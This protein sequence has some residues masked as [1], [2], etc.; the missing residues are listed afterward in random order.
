ML[1]NLLPKN[2]FAPALLVGT[3]VGVGIFGIPYAFAKT[4]PIWGLFLLLG[5]GVVMMLLHYYYG[6]VCLRCDKK[7]RLVGHAERFLGSWA[8]RLVTISLSF[9]FLGA[10]LAYLIVA[11][12]F[13]HV[14]FG[15][16]QIGGWSLGAPFY[17]FLFWVAGSVLVYRGLKTIAVVEVVMSVFLIGVI[18]LIFVTSLGKIEIQNL[19]G[20]NLSFSF[21]AYGVFLTALGGQA[22]IPE[23]REMVKRGSFNKQSLKKVI[24]R[25]TL[26]VVLI[27]LLFGLAVAGVSG[28]A[29]TKEAIQGLIPF[30]G[31]NIALAGAVFGILACFTS[32]LV[33][34]D[35]LKTVFSHDWKLPHLFS[36]GIVT[37]LPLLAYFGG[38][39]DF[40]SIISLVGAVMGGVSGVIIV[41]M[42]NK[43]SGS[44]KALKFVVGAVLTLGIFYHIVNLVKW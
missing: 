36:W 26:G 42:H 6:E 17:A 24:T 38:L 23:M 34:G 20:I 25:T 41:L 11:G 5:L 19:S 37:L 13:L 39:R 43:I 1:S 16:V 2:I 28:K 18:A 21:I 22:A 32:F 40:I 35:N 27:Y 31:K 14:I 8:K 9:G 15:D 44:Y 10:I 12:D 3:M 30:L 7:M 29:T 33:L 4:G